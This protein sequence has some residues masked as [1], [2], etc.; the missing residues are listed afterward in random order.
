MGFA[1]IKNAPSEELTT[2]VYTNTAVFVG[3]TATY[4]FFW[5]KYKMKQGLFKPESIGQA[6]I[7]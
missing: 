1:I 5:I 3:I 2:K 6:L 4:A 7:D